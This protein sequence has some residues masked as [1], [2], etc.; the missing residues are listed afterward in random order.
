MYIPYTAYTPYI[1]PVVSAMYTMYVV[2]I[3]DTA[4]T[5]TKTKI[6]KI[7]FLRKI[8]IFVIKIF[9]KKK[10]T[11]PQ[12]RQDVGFVGQSL[13]CPT[14]SFAREENVKSTSPEK[15]IGSMP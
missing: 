14:N 1:M 12:K 2:A 7:L 9:R 10:I 4:Y 13:I 5:K 11:H 3:S 15:K 6:K 8:P